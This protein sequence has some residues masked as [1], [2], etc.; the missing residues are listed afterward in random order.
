[1][2]TVGDPASVAR[3]HE[4][5]PH[6]LE[7]IVRGRYDGTYDK[8]DIPGELIMTNYYNVAGGKIVSLVV[9]NN[10]SSGY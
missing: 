2:G 1:M 10:R 8:A 6:Y 9:V 3:H 4:V 5:T 7:V